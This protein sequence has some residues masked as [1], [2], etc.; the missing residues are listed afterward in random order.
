MGH[1]APAWLFGRGDLRAEGQ[2]G[3]NKGAGRG[4]EEAAKANETGRNQIVEIQAICGPRAHGLR[5]ARI[6]QWSLAWAP[7]SVRR[8]D[9]PAPEASWFCI[10]S[11]YQAVT[12]LI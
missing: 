7:G 4:L 6:E 10:C 2:L 1:L 11:P 8:L 9:T 3:L 12:R 5:V